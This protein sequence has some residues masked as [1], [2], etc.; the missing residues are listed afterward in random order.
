MSETY[1][2]GVDLGGTNL[3]I[4]SYQG[5][6]DFLESILLPTR[7]A[8]GPDQVVR[9][10]CEGI[11]ALRSSHQ[12]GRRLVGIGIGSPGPMELPEGTL[13]NPPNLPGWDGFQLRQAIESSLGTAVE[14]ESDANLAA[15]AEQKLGAGKTHHVNSLCVL[16]LGT[17]VGSGLILRGRIWHGVT[18]MGGEAGHIIVQDEGGAPCGC[19]GYGCLEQYA[20]ASAVLRMARER[21]RDAA[22]M[23]A[24]DVAILARAGDAA[25]ASVFATVGH[26]LAIALT[27][28]IN[29][30]NLPMYLLG[31]GVCEAWDLF[32]PAMFAELPQ[33]SYIY[34]LT[35][36]DDIDPSSLEKNKTY[37]LGAQLGPAAGLLGACLLPYHSKAVQSGM[38]EDL[39][40]HQ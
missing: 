18:G 36:P 39:L 38:A 26:S 12:G 29:T 27:S 10:I 30:L 5:G 16:T 24:H 11:D 9:D 31:G 2:I 17:G 40:V 13:R 3:R 7:L 6:V 34:R 19:G 28:L 4:A 33:R 32:A 15:L 22:P 20:S 1:S 21:I 37:I 23:T 8:E 35:Q 14:I 25:A